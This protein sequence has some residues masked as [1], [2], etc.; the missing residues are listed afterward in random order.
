[1]TFAPR[2]EMALIEP[3]VLGCW[4]SSSISMPHQ[5]AVCC[6]SA[7]PPPRLATPRRRSESHPRASCRPG[8]R[9]PPTRM[10]THRSAATQ[11]ATVA[12]LAVRRRR[13]TSPDGLPE[14]TGSPRPGARP[15]TR[16]PRSPNP[17]TVVSTPVVA[18]PPRSRREGDDGVAIPTSRTSLGVTTHLLC[19]HPTTRCRHHRSFDP[20]AP[21]P[22]IALQAFRTPGLDGLWAIRTAVSGTGVATQRAEQIERLRCG[23]GSL[24]GSRATGDGPC[25]GRRLAPRSRSTGRTP[26][27]SGAT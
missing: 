25:T 24:F 16:P 27:P 6:V 21:G 4:P 14:P 26:S 10:R 19:Q 3:H 17:R 18:L 22:R 1:M 13:R 9:R 20:S 23:W 2:T 11:P 12:R 7:E 8:R 5:G 15:R